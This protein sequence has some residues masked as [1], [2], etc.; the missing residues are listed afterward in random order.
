MDVDNFLKNVGQFGPFQIK[1]LAMFLL[2]FFP[3]TYQTLIMVFMAYEPPW[4]C[5]E[6]STACLQPNA[7]G[8]EVFSTSTKPIELYQ[9]RCSLNRT[10]WK[11][12]DT[13]LYE[14][15]HRTIVTD[16]SVCWIKFQ[17]YCGLLLTENRLK[18][19]AQ[20]F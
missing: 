3:V 16:V 4:M 7:T 12:A 15:P 14:G 9:R 19:D 1:I 5:V 17:I 18:N 13:N 2:I 6:N 11:F 10:D 8:L 20:G